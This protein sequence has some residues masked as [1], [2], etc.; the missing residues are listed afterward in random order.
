MGQFEF[1]S[2]EMKEQIKNAKNYLEN[3]PALRE[4]VTRQLA[5][6]EANEELANRVI[7]EYT[8]ALEILEPK[9]E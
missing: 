5:E 3:V 2:K 8:A 7:N 1:L 6:I 4:Q 9:E